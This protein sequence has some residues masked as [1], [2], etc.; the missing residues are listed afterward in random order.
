MHFAFDHIVHFIEN[1]EEAIR[2]L[3][4][5]GI[6]A[7]E[8][9][10]HK[11]RPTYNVLSH[12]D[13][14]Y[15][16]YLGTSDR[17]AL[18]EMEHPQHSMI[19]TIMKKGFQEGFVRFI[20]R[21]D[22]IEAAAQRFS[23][24]GLTVNGPVYLSREQPDGSLLEWQLLFIGD[25]KD[26]LELPYFIQ[27][28]ESDEERKKALTEREMIVSHPAE[29]SFSH[30]NIAVNDLERTVDKWS[31][32]LGLETEEPYVDEELQATC[33]KLL[34]SGGDIVFCSPLGAGVVSE[35]LE[36]QG[37]APFQVNLSSKE[38]ADLFEFSG[39]RYQI[40]RNA[41]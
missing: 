30:I 8:G 2:T 23:D 40:K 34:L 17:Q 33:Q 10:A 11:N 25:E 15:I 20:I 1:P 27:W 36:Q 22:N 18:E 7:V 9:G 24:K 21:T 12:F 26:E 28:N 32:L 39:G 19:Q 31:D 5:K 6:H 35:A 4:S 3:K 29:A 16:E 13:L 14:S 37:E 41:K 38:I